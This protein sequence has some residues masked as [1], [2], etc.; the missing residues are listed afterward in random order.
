MSYTGI[1]PVTPT[2]FHDDGKLDLEGMHRVLD[3]L[4]EQGEIRQRPG[5]GYR[6]GVA[7]LSRRV[8]KRERAAV[9]YPLNFGH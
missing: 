5:G 2:P 9:S 7:S 3:C 8:A 1:W 6:H 4:I